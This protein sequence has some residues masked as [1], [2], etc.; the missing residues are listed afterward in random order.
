MLSSPCSLL[1]AWGILVQGLL[2]VGALSTLAYKRQLEQP[3]RPRLTWLLDASKQALSSASG[4]FQNVALS[5]LVFVRLHV[6]ATSP[7]VWYLVNLVLDTTLGTALAFY[8]LRTAEALLSAGAR[9]A[10]RPACARTLLEAAET[11]QYGAPPQISRWAAQLFVWLLVT[12]CVKAVV[13]AIILVAAMPLHSAGLYT[14]R[15]LQPYPR[16][17]VVLVVLV[18]P[19][20]LNVMQMWIQDNFLQQRA[21]PTRGAPDGLIQAVAH[22]HERCTACAATCGRGGGCSRGTYAK[23]TAR[24][25]ASSTGELVGLMLGS[26]LPVLADDDADDDD[27]EPLRPLDERDEPDDGGGDAHAHAEAEST[28]ERVEPRASGTAASGAARRAVAVGGVGGVGGRGAGLHVQPAGAVKACGAA[29][30]APAPSPVALPVS[31]RPCG[32]TALGNGHSRQGTPLSGAASVGASPRGNLSA[33]SPPP[34]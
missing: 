12:T 5:E 2:G 17:Q 16:A 20:L 25:R 18:V 22:V 26:Q 6:A 23:C 21:H 9:L 31:P 28:R 4:H 15:P 34:A 8:A 1:D 3:C 14:L 19:L 32:L 29:D 33:A 10:P 11:G 13:A 24:A 30:G 27:D 7:C